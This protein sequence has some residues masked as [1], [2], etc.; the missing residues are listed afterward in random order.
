MSDY[1]E[2]EYFPI[3]LGIIRENAVI[4]FDCF[5]LLRTNQRIVRLVKQNEPFDKSK[6][7]KLQSFKFSEVYVHE[8]DRAAYNEYLR[9]FFKTDEGATVL[10]E[11]L[12]VNP[13][14]PIKGLP[15][16]VRKEFTEPKA[17][18]PKKEEPIQKKY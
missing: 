11:T 10:K 18:E 7:D 15:D 5:I 1:N 6:L 13:E 17:Q 16:E 4:P 2:K 9:E 3:L 14:G 12:A 8:N